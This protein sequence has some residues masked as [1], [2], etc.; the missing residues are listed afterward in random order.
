MTITLKFRIF[1]KITKINEKINSKSNI[2]ILFIFIIIK[3]IIL[4]LIVRKKK[5]IIYIVIIIIKNDLIS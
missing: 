3:K 5:L 1:I 2:K 4:N